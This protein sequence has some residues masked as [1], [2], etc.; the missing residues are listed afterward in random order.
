VAETAI[1]VPV[2]AAEPLIREWRRR[3]TPSGADGMPAHVTLL[4][5]FT[6]SDELTDERVDAAESALAKFAP[7][8]LTLARCRYF[9]DGPVLYLEP[10][11]PE[12]FKA[13][14]AALVRTFP[15]HPPYGGAHPDPTPH[16]TVAVEIPREELESIERQLAPALP[17]RTTVEDVWLVAHDPEGWIPIQTFRLRARVESST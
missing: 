6:D 11:P 16:V 4:V 8:E 2:L 17:I 14:T 10:E 7:V 15:E 12:P 3:Y 1:V 9:D 5:P 13:M